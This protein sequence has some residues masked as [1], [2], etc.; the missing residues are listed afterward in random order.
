[1]PHILIVEDDPKLGPRLKRNLELSGYGVSLARDG[2]TGLNAAQ[3]GGFDLILLDLMLPY[4]GGLNILNDLRLELNHTPVIILTA[5]GMEVDRLEGFRA[6]CDDYV[7]KPFSMDELTA[8]IK[9]VLR[10]V[11]FKSTPRAITSGGLLLDPERFTASCN[12]QR[13]EMTNR[14][15]DLLYEL[16]SR[17]NL[18]MSRYALLDEVWGEEFDASVRSVDALVAFIRKK[19][20]TIKSLTGSIETVYK[21]GYRWRVD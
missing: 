8:R 5:K 9:A 18:P 19:L 14:E 2:L 20:E 10:R 1:M 13:I 4:I 6:G 15:F 21:V 16:V 3:K 17:P 12:G 7:T 11:G